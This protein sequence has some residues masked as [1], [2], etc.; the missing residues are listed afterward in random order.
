VQGEKN[1]GELFYFSKNV[2][3]ATGYASA[4]VENG[5]Y[6][7]AMP[8]GFKVNVISNLTIGGTAISDFSYSNG[9]L[10]IATS[11]VGSIASGV[12]GMNFK[13]DGIKH[14]AI[15]TVADLVMKTE[16]D[17]YKLRSVQS[18]QSSL[19]VLDGDIACSS[20]FVYWSGS[21]WFYGT[22]D[23]KG[24]AIKNLKIGGTSEKTARLFWGFQPNAVA[25]NIALIDVSFGPDVTNG[26]IFGTE[27]ATSVFENV[28]ISIAEN[29]GRVLFDFENVLNGEKKEVLPKTKVLKAVNNV[30]KK[31]E[32]DFSGVKKAIEKTLRKELSKEEEKSVLELQ[33]ALLQT[34]RGELNAG[35]KEDVNEGLSSLLKIMSKYAV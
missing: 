1:G 10:K 35:I 13:A 28:F 22:L 33:L 29:K 4:Y 30:Q 32:I 27:S 23:G 24:Y 6:K 17:F 12:V 2:T 14:Q 8:Q 18:T 25:K 19:F 9:V 7:I 34:E 3:D 15:V 31:G 16:S 26:G 20:S 21:L 5:Y 11:A